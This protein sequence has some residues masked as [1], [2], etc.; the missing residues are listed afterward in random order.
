MRPT[1]R[2]FIWTMGAAATGLG[3]QEAQDVFWARDPPADT[4]WAPEV[5]TGFTSTCLVCPGRCGIRGRTVD[6]RLV[7]ITG[8]PHHPMT[9]GG[10]CPRGIAGVQMLYH[11]ERIASP[12]LRAGPR[13]A[14]QWTT[15]SREGALDLIGQRLQ[16]LRSAGRPHALAALTGYCSGSMQDLWQQFFHAFGSPNHLTEWYDDGTDAVMALMHGATRRPS[17][18]L[19]QSDVVL[20]FGAPLF[21]SWWSP[22]QAA[23]AYADPERLRERGAR[24]IQVDTR[25]SKTATRAHEWVG[26]RP[27]SHAVLAL[28]IAYVLIRDEAFNADFVAEHVTGFE[29]LVD[30]E[31]RRREGYRSLVMRNYRT[32]EVSTVTGVPVERITE[33]ARTFAESPRGVAIC[34]ADVTYAPTGLLAGLAVHSLNVLTGNINRPGGVLFGQDAPVAPLGPLVID[35]VA[36]AGNA[37]TP[38]GGAPPAFGHTNQPIRFAE[39]VAS[40]DDPAID[41]LFLYYANPL[42][43]SAD[44][45]RW[46][47]ALEKIPFVVSFSPFLDETTAHADVVLPDLLSYERWQDAPAPVSYPYPIWGIAQPMVEPHKGG[48]HTGDALLGIAARLEGGVAESL[49]YDSFEALITERARGLFTARRGMIFGSEFER[50]H[51]QQMEQRGWWLPEHGDFE[52]FWRDLVEQGGWADLFHDYDDPHGR[53]RTAS[54][55]IT[56]LPPELFEALDAEEHKHRP[57]ID[58]MASE[59][60]ASEEYPLRLIPYRGSTLASGTLGLERWLVEQPAVVPDVHWVPWVEVHPATARELGLHD[61]AMVWVVSPRGRYRARLKTFTGTARDNVC[62]PYSLKHP[63]GELASPLQ[64]LDGAADALTG[65]PAWFTTRVRLESA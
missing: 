3:L 9:R 30:E 17:Y 25:F 37:R 41:S 65:L 45:A 52:E 49:P 31:G 19:E 54:G 36:E 61:D 38:I 29:D 10:V 6:G 51:H 34:G 47:E 35:D 58:V 7:G 13:G 27:G 64:L 43:S 26:I 15:A 5:E 32:E 16:G 22:L 33:L 57:Y 40:Q 24:F 12:L 1:R 48:T 39:A 50:R 55:R 46:R 8:N 63:D 42:A 59:P 20:S 56:L 4:G 62:A 11:P 2:E 28:G 23:V 44:P 53:V 18:D 21:E 60:E 14:G